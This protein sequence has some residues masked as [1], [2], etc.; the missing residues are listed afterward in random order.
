MY[1]INIRNIQRTRS[2]IRKWKCYTLPILFEIE[3]GDSMQKGSILRYNDQIIW[4]TK[5]I[6]TLEEA[7]PDVSHALLV[8][9]ILCEPLHTTT[10]LTLP[11]NM[12]GP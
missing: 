8:Y 10:Q 5:K 1:V 4:G 9:D 6:L 3:Y 2:I 7:W 11:E 12:D